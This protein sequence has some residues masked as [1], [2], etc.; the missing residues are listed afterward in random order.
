MQK[1][2][3]KLIELIQPLHYFFT[4]RFNVL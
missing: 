2:A 3:F 1:K 4:A